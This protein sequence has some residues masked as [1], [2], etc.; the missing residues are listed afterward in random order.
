M[1]RKIYFATIF[2]LAL[3]AC[4]RFEDAEVTERQ[5]F[6]H[7]YRSATNFVASVAEVDTDGGFILSGEVNYDDGSTDAVIIKTDSRGR[8]VW[9]KVIRK[10]LINAI[11]P[12]ASGYILAGDSIQLNPGSSQVHELENSYARLVI[13]DAQ[14]N[15]VRQ[16]IATDSIK[17]SVDNND[18]V[19]LTV[20]YHGEALAIDE[21][22]GNAIM[23]GSFRVPDKNEASFV[24]A[25]APADVTNWLWYRSYHSLEH[26][27]INC[28]ALHMTPSSSLVWASNTFTQ[29]QNV[30]REYLNI[31]HVAPNSAHKNNSVFGESETSH[32]HSVNDIQKAS[33]G[34]GAIGTFSETSG[35]NAN[36]YFVRIDASMNVVPGSARYID[37]EDLMLTNTIMDSQTKT[38]SVSFDEG[39]AIAATA[40]GYVL[41]GAMT[42]TPTVGNGGKDILLVKVDPFGNLLWKKLIGGSGDEVIASVR[43]TPDG[44]LLLFGTNTINGLSS[45]MLI[46]TDARGETKD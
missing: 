45:L 10:G 5:T 24:S 14:G 12:T 28:H 22:T 19:T 33:V 27:L 7:F 44:G 9:E 31:S 25:F 2:L 15:I 30:T 40:D 38:A 37:G 17:K 3:E 41:A 20:D 8:K 1:Q 4:T 29:V 36:M 32:N 42:S 6:V 16:H 21:A 35:L 18:V 34:Y 13:M 11:K 43:E 39:L 46:K 26:D 23:L